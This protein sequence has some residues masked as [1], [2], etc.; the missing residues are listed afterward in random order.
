MKIESKSTLISSIL[1]I[2]GLSICLWQASINNNDQ[3]VKPVLLKTV[4]PVGSENKNLRRQ[5][6]QARDRIHTLEKNAMKHIKNSALSEGTDNSIS[7]FHETSESQEPSDIETE[8]D[9]SAAGFSNEN[10]MEAALEGF[11]AKFFQGNEDLDWTE[12]TEVELQKAFKQQ[13]VPDTS[14]DAVQCQTNL[15]VV[16]FVHQ[17]GEGHDLLLQRLYGI[18]PFYG[19]FLVKSE[20]EGDQLRTLVYF[21]RAGESLSKYI[22]LNS[23]ELL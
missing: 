14:I 4:P 17:D 5:L 15:C 12:E 10:E 7:T 9:Y 11:E 16:E 6:A 13:N 8:Q 19:G 2:G 23:G 18:K 1:I 20:E 22:N 3:T 21:P